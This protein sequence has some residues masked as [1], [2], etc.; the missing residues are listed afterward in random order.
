[1][2]TEEKTPVKA[3]RARS[4]ASDATIYKAIEAVINDGDINE[5]STVDELLRELKDRHWAKT[6]G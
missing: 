3:K 4:G 5:S 2:T 6:I 1:M